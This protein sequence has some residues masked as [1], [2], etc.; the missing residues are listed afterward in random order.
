MRRRD[1][2]RES[3]D[4]INTAEYLKEY[5]RNILSNIPV[6]ILTV[7]EGLKVTDANRNFYQK[8]RKIPRDV[9]NV[10]IN[11][12]F[13]P[14]FIKT[15]GLRLKIE[16]VLKTRLPEK[17][18]IESRNR[19]YDYH[20]I[21]QMDD[22]GRNTAILIMDD[23][24][25]RIRL[26]AQILQIEWHL[27]NV[28]ESASDLVFS[29]NSRGKILT[30]NNAAE[31]ILGYQFEK[32][33]GKNFLSLF[34]HRDD[35]RRIRGMFRELKKGKR[36]RSCEF[37]MPTKEKDKEAL[38]SWAFGTVRSKEGKVLGLMGVGRD[39]TEKNR[40][41]AQLIQS[42][43][44]ASLG[45]M[46]GGMAHELRNPLAIAQ[47]AAQFLLEKRGDRLTRECSEKICASVRRS[48]D[49]IEN[50]LKFS[51]PTPTHET[52]P[53]DINIIID[54]TLSLVEH[55]ILLQNIKISKNY[56]STKEVAGN[57]NQLQQVFMNLILN[58]SH[59]MKNGGK[60][61]IIT[62]DDDDDVEIKFVDTGYG[63]PKTDLERIFDPFFTT[64]LEER[65][66]GLGLFVSYGIIQQHKGAIGV[67]SQVGKGTTVTVK[68]PMTNGN[69]MN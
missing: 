45:T 30:W 21:H 35:K 22:N 6:S 49:I 46:A 1:L 64:K 27:A 33:E 41:E 40:L 19:V 2:R 32:L 50:L 4:L 58:A 34:S 28:M 14:V 7:N 47:G 51:Q 43:K 29:A 26:D 67:Q 9:I 5:N 13:P 10:D 31:K 44:M 3:R 17:G 57:P 11:H 52:K 60:L 38:I 59:A 56:A 24:T 15:M 25:E 39:L 66:T 20:I 8:T 63:I 55:Q 54:E 16:N 62:K 61:K 12:I 69:A 18:Q 68:L 23:V 53:I 37:I 48:T 65:G 42:A 36:L